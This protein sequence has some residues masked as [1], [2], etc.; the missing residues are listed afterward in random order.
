MTQPT[1]TRRS[2]VKSAAALGVP[3]GTTT[4][5][6]QMAELARKS[7]GRTGPSTKPTAVDDTSVSQSGPTIESYNKV[8]A[9]LK[10]RRDRHFPAVIMRDRIEKA[11]QN[12]QITAEDRKNLLNKYGNG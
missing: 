4:Y 6:V 11:Y 1:I 5:A 7:S 9:E 8:V 10:L 3:L 12:R 2:F